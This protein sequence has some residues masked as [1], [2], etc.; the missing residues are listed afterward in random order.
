MMMDSLSISPLALL[1]SG[2]QGAYP[3]KFQGNHCRLPGQVSQLG[4]GLATRALGPL[5]SVTAS[6][7][8]LFQPL[9]GCRAPAPRGWLGAVSAPKPW[10]PV[11]G[12]AG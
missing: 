6:L 8:P 12:G 1:G 5:V 4:Q 2:W 3:C 10:E 7:G 11:V 9:E